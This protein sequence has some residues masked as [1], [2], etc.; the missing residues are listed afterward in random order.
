MFTGIIK[1]TSKVQD[2]KFPKGG[3]SID[4]L[5]NLGKIKLGESISING[6]CSTVKKTGKNISFEYMPETLKL[7]NVSLLKK[8]DIVNIEQSMRMSDR[9]DGHIV[10]GHID[11][12]GKIISIKKEGNSKVFEI[13]VPTRNFMKF[14]VYKGSVAVEGISLTVVKVTHDSFVV[15]I[16]PHTLEHTNLKPKKAGD[17]VNLE[18]DILAKY[19][20]KK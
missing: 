9:L 3:F 8:G 18:F 13:K 5:N 2:V 6:V 7:S 12:C 17:A 4:I 19:A 1:K 14:L 11:T 15:K 16:I 20:N 10:L